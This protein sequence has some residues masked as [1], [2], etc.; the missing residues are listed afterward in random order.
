LRAVLD[1]NVIISAA[2]SP[3]GSLARIFRLWFEGGYELVC[4]PLLLDELAR[5]F[6]YPKLKTHI[7]SD[8]AEELNQLLRRG[9][10]MVDDPAIPLDVSSS[11]PNDDYLVALAGKS[12]SVL[13]S[14]D[15]DLL[16]LSERIPVY[17]PSDFL[18]LIEVRS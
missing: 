9:A 5:T 8:E 2:L 7:H 10:L 3:R 12:R 14:G 6:T 13:V 17:S 1:P 15:R 18:R 16:A 4:S 11:D